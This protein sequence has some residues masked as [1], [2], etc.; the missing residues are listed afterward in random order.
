MFPRSWRKFCSRVM[1]SDL[2]GW[3]TSWQ[4]K[5][6]LQIFSI[7]LSTPG[8]YTMILNFLFRLK[9]PGRP[10]WPNIKHRFLKALWITF[11]VPLKTSLPSANNSLRSGKYFLYVNLSNFPFYKH[12]LTTIRFGSWSDTLSISR[13]VIATGADSRATNLIHSSDSTIFDM[14]CRQDL[15]LA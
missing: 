15:C 13:V 5:H 11:R 6:V 9:V 7:S 10:S 2:D 4:S 3:L 14:S 1:G 8:Q 12:S